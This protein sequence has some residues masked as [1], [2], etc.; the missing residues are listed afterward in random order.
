MIERLVTGLQALSA[1]PPAALAGDGAASARGDCADAVRL[2]LDCPQE[3]LGVGERRA[4][5]ELFDV[6]EGQ[7]LDGPAIAAAVRRARETLRV[8]PP[9]RQPPAA[10]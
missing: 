7:S 8:A 5:V 9:T 1:L 4:L 3:E 10:R 6:L 2:A